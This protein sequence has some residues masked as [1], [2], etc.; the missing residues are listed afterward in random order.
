MTT[1]TLRTS[2]MVLLIMAIIDV[3]YCLLPFSGCRY[4]SCQE[5]SSEGAYQEVRRFESHLHSKVV[6]SFSC[7]SGFSFS[8]SMTA[9]P[10]VV[11]FTPLLHPPLFSFVA[12]SLSTLFLCLLFPLPPVRPYTC[13]PHGIGTFHSERKL[14]ACLCWRFWVCR[15]HLWSVRFSGVIGPHASHS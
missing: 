1:V 5:G 2:M 15:D 8:S 13:T 14:M 11:S 4:R 3:N 9:F 12:L 10:F 7:V 6:C